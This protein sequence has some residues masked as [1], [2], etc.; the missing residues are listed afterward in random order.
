[1]VAVFDYVHL[2]FGDCAGKKIKHPATGQEVFSHCTAAKGTVV[3]VSVESFACRVAQR[4]PPWTH[5][6]TV[7]CKHVK[8]DKVCHVLGGRDSP[9]LLPVTRGMQE[10]TTRCLARDLKPFWISLFFGCARILINIS[11]ITHKKK[12][13][14]L[15]F[16]ISKNERRGTCEPWNI[17]F[18][19]RRRVSLVPLKAVA[20]ISGV[21]EEQNVANNVNG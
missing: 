14:E 6:S 12:K 15:C 9:D 2:N 16:E 21:E 18:E 13:H 5:D 11:R 3:G 8:V 19:N 17:C 7:G 10:C 20:M 1:M 4:L